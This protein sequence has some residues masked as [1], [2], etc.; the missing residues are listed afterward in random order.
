MS[1]PGL[2]SP[3]L[4]LMHPGP[5]ETLTASN[6]QAQVVADA[7]PEVVRALAR[8]GYAY[9]LC[10]WRGDLWRVCL[11]RCGPGQGEPARDS[12]RPRTS[13]CRSVAKSC[14]TLQTPMDCSTPSLPVLHLL[15]FAQT[16]VHG[17]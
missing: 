11:Q 9:K 12:A 2:P 15:E 1:S 5:W 14:M 10:N 13:C 8:K 3:T 4:P 16:H 17:V 6:K 7:S